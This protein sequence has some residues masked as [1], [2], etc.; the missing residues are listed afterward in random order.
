MGMSLVFTSIMMILM[1]NFINGVGMDHVL[2]GAWMG[3]TIDATGAVAATVKKTLD[4]TWP[5]WPV[6]ARPGNAS[7]GTGVWRHA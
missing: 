2:G 6:P 1:P 7:E 3:G 4:P 5:T